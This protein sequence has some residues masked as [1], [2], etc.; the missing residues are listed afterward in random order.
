MLGWRVC[1][2]P[3][4]LGADPGFPDLVLVRERVVFVELK[5][6]AGKLSQA[7]ADWIQALKA[8]GAEVHTWWPDDLELAAK[9]LQKHTE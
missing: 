8:A 4:S 1:Y 2:W 6:S 7:Q 5:G 9:I 3:Y